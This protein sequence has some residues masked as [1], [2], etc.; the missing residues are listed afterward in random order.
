MNLRTRKKTWRV[1]FG[2]RHGRRNASKQLTICVAS[3][4][5]SVFCLA[6][7]LT[8]FIHRRLGLLL[9]ETNLLSF[10]TTFISVILASVIVATI[11]GLLFL[12]LG[13]KLF[14]NCVD[15]RVVGL[16][17]K[18]LAVLSV[19]CALSQLN[20]V[21]FV[22]QLRQVQ[23]QP[24]ATFD[25]NANLMM[26][27]NCHQQ[28]AP[29]GSAVHLS[30]YLDILL[31]TSFLLESSAQQK[32]S[33]N[34]SRFLS[35]LNCANS[36]NAASKYVESNRIP[37]RFLLHKCGLICEKQRQQLHQFNDDIF[38]RSQSQEPAASQA[39]DRLH[40]PPAEDST[41]SGANKMLSL[42]ICFSGE[43][44][45]GANYKRF[46]I[47]NLVNGNS[48]DEASGQRG[49][50][51]QASSL[52]LRQVNQMLSSRS[53]PL[54]AALAATGSREFEDQLTHFV[55]PTI[56]FESNFKGWPQS[57]SEHDK[58][59]DWCSLRPMPPF[60]V[61]NKPYS[62][63]QCSIAEDYLVSEVASTVSSNIYLRRSSL[64]P[65]ASISDQ[66]S[67]CNIQCKVNILYQVKVDT[68]SASRR[69]QTGHYYLPLRPCLVVGAGNKALTVSKYVLARVLFDT[70][71][72]TT[73][74]I[75]AEL[76][77]IERLESKKSFESRARLLGY[78]LP[79]LLLPTIVGL[80]MDAIK[81]HFKVETY[82]SADVICEQ[83]LPESLARLVCSRV[84]NNASKSISQQQ[85]SSQQKTSPPIIVDK[86]L[87][88]FFASACFMVS[89]ASAS[90]SLAIGG[91]KSSSNRLA[92]F[93]S[94]EQLG[95]KPKRVIKLIRQQTSSASLS[96]LQK[97][98][99]AFYLAL[100]LLLG[101]A[102]N[103]LLLV[104][105]EIVSSAY[106]MS[107]NFLP[108]L[109]NYSLPAGLILVASLCIAALKA[110][111]SASL[112]S[113]KPV[114]ESMLGPTFLDG[115]LGIALLAF[116]LKLRALESLTQESSR[117][118][119]PLIF[120]VHFL[121]ILSFPL[122]WLALSGRMSLLLV[123]KLSFENPRQ[124]LR[125]KLHIFAHLSFLVIFFVLGK[126]LARLVH[127]VSL[128]A[129]ILH[130]KIDWFIYR[131]HQHQT[132]PAHS[133]ITDSAQFSPLPSD[134]EIFL[135]TCQRLCES[136]SW[137]CFGTSLVMLSK[138][139]YTQYL[140]RLRKKAGLSV[141][142]KP[143]DGADNGS[144]IDEQLATDLKYLHE[145]PASEEEA[146]QTVKGP[147]KVYSKYNVSRD[148]M[149]SNSSSPSQRPTKLPPANIA[150]AKQHKR[151]EFNV[152]VQLDNI[153]A[154]TTADEASS[155]YLDTSPAI[156]PVA[157]TQ[158]ATG[159]KSA[160]SE[161]PTS[162]FGRSLESI[163]RYSSRRRH[164][165][166]VSTN[167]S[168]PSSA[169]PKMPEAQLIARKVS[170]EP[171]IGSTTEF[172][173]DECGGS[174]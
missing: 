36:F 120:L 78:L 57:V 13:K 52:T 15:R 141:D 80:L 17:C 166:F 121:D 28:F 102:F 167:T 151:V 145:Q 100:I 152:P 51:K 110:S 16:L 24:T 9:V 4:A 127:S 54:E 135:H 158:A 146:G 112:K 92:R 143:G 126:L 12:L 96:G 10:K 33:S 83:V 70:S 115:F 89:L 5:S 47:T 1:V 134:S 136:I 50:H 7:F 55:E 76:L 150:R 82:V 6:P 144:T 140:L 29:I 109:I 107:T 53:S 26:I 87:V 153:S 8:N 108:P 22:P 162:G 131:H 71:L 20:L 99:L 77:L 148:N 93:S 147:T 172:E 105:D 117:S 58:D 104:G 38:I 27:E 132:L 149:S 79:T 2:P 67:R 62:D 69:N 116:A 23:R 43:F 63:I 45:T 155:K 129:V 111:D 138:F 34:K 39:S 65:S 165:K 133:T 103:L 48:D 123:Q 139:A 68:S 113:F 44:S 97:G 14:E 154:S 3:Y 88:P 137:L 173:T 66:P 164:F 64:D 95:M 156:S 35:N 98:F 128:S 171:S 170:P 122:I 101:T 72:L 90:F 118:K 94:A 25:C 168:E 49:Q 161:P 46:C 130:G 169:R 41:T 60:V 61:N 124:E 74:L 106:K 84:Q 11:N 114:L 119:L 160:R 163:V 75:L 174:L 42:K 56:Q 31:S 37:T 40:Q 30:H 21:F 73:G 157:R 81:L 86:Y 19:L 142:G 159:T 125:R 85:E 91:S 18:I 32:S 59:E